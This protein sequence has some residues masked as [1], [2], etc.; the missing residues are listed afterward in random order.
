MDFLSLKN[1][2]VESRIALLR[3][4]GYDSDGIYVLNTDKTKKIDVYI[5]EPIKVSNVA[6]LPGSLVVIDDNPVS[7]A[8]Y[9]EEHGDAI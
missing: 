9:L 7:I 2:S 4:I 3:E 5:D 8:A 6:I 1:I